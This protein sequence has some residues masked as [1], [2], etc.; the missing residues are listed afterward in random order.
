MLLPTLALPAAE[1]PGGPAERQI[2]QP[3]GLEEP[4]AVG[5]FL[6]NVAGDS[7]LAV[8]QPRRKGLHPV[9][10]GGNVHIRDFRDVFAVDF[11]VQGFG[12]EP[13]SAA[14]RTGFLVEKMFFSDLLP[15]TFPVFAR[16]EL[17]QDPGEGGHFHIRFG[18]ADAQQFVGP[19]EDDLQGLFGTGRCQPP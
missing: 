14:Y 6:E 17:R 19:A 11:E 3:Y 10:E 8:G 15:L 13:R 1:R 2:V 18:R 16:R 7:P 12:L 5:Q 9:T 4:D